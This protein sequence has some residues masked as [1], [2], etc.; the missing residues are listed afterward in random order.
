MFCEIADGRA[1]KIAQVRAAAKQRAQVGRECAHVRTRRTTNLDAD[2]KRVLCW[3]YVV[4]IHS[5][6]PGLAL[7][8]NTF[9]RQFVQTPAV[10]AQRRDHGRHLHNLARQF[11]C[12][13]ANL[14]DAQVGHVV[15]CCHYTRAVK[16]VGFGTKNNFGRICLVHATQK[17]HQ[18]RYVAHTNEQDSCCVGVECSGMTNATFAKNL[19]QL[20]YYVVAGDTRGLI[21]DCQTVH[22]WRTALGHCYSAVVS[23]VRLRVCIGSLRNTSSM[24]A[25]AR[26]ASSGR[27][28]RIGVRRA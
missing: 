16:R 15:S 24:R 28:S 13:L 14:F 18:A 7:D 11:G 9:A 6:W 27:N 2:N 1:S 19:S 26:M 17:L 22:G 3:L 12:C 23:S 4:R 20:I 10:Y 5:D 21:D 8:N 25:A